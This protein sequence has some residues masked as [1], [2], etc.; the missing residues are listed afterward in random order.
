M[1]VEVHQ[2]GE[3][4]FYKFFKGLQRRGILSFEFLILNGQKVES[5]R[6]EVR[7]Q[8]SEV[9]GQRSK[10]LLAGVGVKGFL[11]AKLFLTAK[12]AKVFA[13]GSK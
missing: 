9:R 10:L 2:V 11:G 1:L 8:R 3:V 5:Q 7:G 12:D 6:S 4:F 13:K